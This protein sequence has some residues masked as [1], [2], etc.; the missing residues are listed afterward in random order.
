VRLTAFDPK[1]AV[2]AKFFFPD[3]HGVLD[4]VDHKTA[5]SKGIG[6]VRA[7]HHDGY[8]HFTEGEPAK[9]VRDGQLA[10]RPAPTGLVRNLL[11]LGMGHG[12]V[13]F[14]LQA[15]HLLP[16]GMIADAPQKYDDTAAA[17]VFRV[18]QQLGEINGFVGQGN[19]EFR[20]NRV[21][22]LLRLE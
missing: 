11:H 12:L 14:V 5:G 19:H 4:R 21:V 7:R 15:D 22:V 1:T 18:R 8:A 9:A 17:V 10:H 6:T 2:G 13:C 16:L 3:G 20:F